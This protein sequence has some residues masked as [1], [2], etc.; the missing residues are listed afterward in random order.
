MGLHS[1]TATERDG[2]Y[3]GAVVNRAARV[4]A[5]GRGG[6]ILLSAATADLLADEG[7]TM[8]DLGPHFL[9][10]LE[11]PERIVRLDAARPAGGRACPACQP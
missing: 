6:Q 7:L 4:A 3:F 2:N 10:G 1:G 11:R 5:T 9:K 8:V